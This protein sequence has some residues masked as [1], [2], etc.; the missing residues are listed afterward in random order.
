MTYINGLLMEIIEKRRKEA[1]LEEGAS[2]EHG[3]NDLLTNVDGGA[4]MRGSP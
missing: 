3:E 1:A 2:G 4:M